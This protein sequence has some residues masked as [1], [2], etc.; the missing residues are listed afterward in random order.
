MLNQKR[1]RGQPQGGTS[2]VVAATIP[3]W[4]LLLWSGCDRHIIYRR[5][6][7]E[8]DVRKKPGA[9]GGKNASACL[10]CLGDERK[11]RDVWHCLHNTTSKLYVNGVAAFSE[12]LFCIRGIIQTQSATLGVKRQQLLW[13]R[14]Y[15]DLWVPVKFLA[16]W[17]VSLSLRMG[18]GSCVFPFMLQNRSSKQKKKLLAAQQL[19][20]NKQVAKKSNKKHPKRRAVKRISNTTRPIFNP[21]F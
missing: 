2:S 9:D 10:F 3:V 4:S 13:G 12:I 17:W 11:T 18:P 19:K 14:V 20:H 6:Q 1:W 7:L 5:V 21:T 8:Q 16:D 15:A